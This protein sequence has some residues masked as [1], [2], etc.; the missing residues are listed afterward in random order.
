MVET[1]RDGTGET[2][3]IVVY[4]ESAGDDYGVSFT[5]PQYPLQLGVIR[6]PLGHII[7]AHTHRPVVRELEVVGTCEV[8]VVA[9][10]AMKVTLYNDDREKVKVVGLVKGDAILLIGGGHEVECCG[11]PTRLI[12]VK[13]GPYAEG[14]K[15]RWTE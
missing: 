12:E 10:G 2:L 13:Q 6:Q 3:A 9:E 1:V 5:S 11:E 8:L 7:P 15:V 14:D 4:R